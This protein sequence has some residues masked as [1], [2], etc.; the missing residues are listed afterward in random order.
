MQCG[1]CTPYTF[2]LKQIVKAVY[3][4]RISPLAGK[5]CGSYFGVDIQAVFFP[6]QVSSSSAL[7]SDAW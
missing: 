4:G 5:A 2:H 7:F 1:T 6:L 3:K